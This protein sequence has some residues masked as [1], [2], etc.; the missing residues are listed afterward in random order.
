MIFKSFKVVFYSTRD[1]RYNIYLKILDNN[2]NFIS[3]KIENID[4]LK[5]IGIKTNLSIDFLRN[6]FY[7]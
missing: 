3:G 2:Q 7:F 1:I 5:G 4:L 6:G